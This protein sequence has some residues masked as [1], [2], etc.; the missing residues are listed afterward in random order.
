MVKGVCSAGTWP[1]RALPTFGVFILNGGVG[2]LRRFLTKR[3][4]AVVSPGWSGS[5][6]GWPGVT[7][8]AQGGNSSLVSVEHSQAAASRVALKTL[9]NFPASGR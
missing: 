3:T 4:R 6:C 1:T 2:A 8:A 5:R 7:P 9:Y